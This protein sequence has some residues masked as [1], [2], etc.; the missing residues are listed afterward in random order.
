MNKAQSSTWRKWVI[1]GTH[2]AGGASAKR[3]LTREI[4][5]DATGATHM[6]TMNSM[7]DSPRAAVMPSLNRFL[8]KLPVSMVPDSVSSWAMTGNLW[9]TKK[10]DEAKERR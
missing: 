10:A 8:E 4:N 9:G 1:G 6:D 7:M 2:G 5:E 3:A